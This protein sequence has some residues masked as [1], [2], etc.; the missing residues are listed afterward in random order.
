MSGK[1]NWDGRVKKEELGLTS[2]GGECRATHN[3]THTNDKRGLKKLGH[4]NV[5]FDNI[6]PLSFSLLSHPLISDLIL[7]NIL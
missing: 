1:V 6:S 7:T 3:F 4:D 2:T 5:V